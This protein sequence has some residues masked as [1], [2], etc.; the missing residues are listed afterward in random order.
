M[1]AQAR[2]NLFACKKPLEPNI[3]KYN[4]KSIR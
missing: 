3:E 1:T 2:K 4:I